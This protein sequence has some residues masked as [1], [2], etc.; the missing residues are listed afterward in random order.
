MFIQVTAS[1]GSGKTFQL[2]KRFLE[3]LLGAS[4]AQWPPVCLKAGARRHA[5]AEIMAITFTNKAAAEMKERLVA[6][7][8]AL[9]LGIECPGAPRGFTPEIARTHLEMLFKH[10]QRLQIRT[11]DSLLV[12]LARLFAVELGLAPDFETVF[13][14]AEILTPLYDRL[15]SRAEAGAEPEASLLARATAAFSGAG[16]FLPSTVWNERLAAM[17]DLRLT[18]PGELATDPR[19][20]VRLRG[21]G[22]DAL[23]S[24]AGC[25]GRELDAAGCKAKTQFAALLEKCLALGPEDKLPDSVYAAKDDFADCVLAAGRAK[26]TPGLDAGYEAFK[27]CFAEYAQTAALTG[28]ALDMLAFVELADALAHGL[29][30]GL[31]ERGRL[32]HVRVAALV[33]NALARDQGVP[34]AFCR[35]GARLAHLLIDEF[36][37]TSRA[38]WRALT[39][40]ALECLAKGGGLFLVGDVKQAIYG[41]R[42]GDARLFAE[43]ARDPELTAMAE[44][45]ILGLTDNWR[46]APRIVDFNNDFFGALARPGRARAA[47][48]A[49][50]AA[51][52]EA[53][54][55]ALAERI[56]EVFGQAAQTVPASRAG[57]PA[58]LVSIRPTPGA[59][60]QDI[61]AGVRQ[62]LREALCDDVLS[63]RPCGDAAILVGTNDLAGEVSRW[64]LDWDVPAVT[65]NS[66]RLAERPVIRQ[67]TAFL[68]FLDYPL[69]DAAFWEFASGAELFGAVSGLG[70][71]DL[72][73]WLAGQGRGALYPQFRRDFPDAWERL[74]RPYFS[75][76]GLTGAYDLAAE[77]I[78]AYRVLARLPGDEGFVRRFLEAVHV[79]GE[80]GHASLAAFLDHWRRKGAGEMAPRPQSLDAVRI[81]TVHKAKGLQFPVVIVP[82][83]AQAAPKA[84]EV[85]VIEKYGLRFA[86]KLSAHAGEPYH[87]RIEAR[88]LEQLNQLYVAWTRAAEELHLF[89][90]PEAR[91]GSPLLDTALRLLHGLGID[92]GERRVDLGERPAPVRPPAPEPPAAAAGPAPEEAPPPGVSFSPPMHWLPRLKVY[93]NAVTELRPDT[94]LTETA[95]GEAA[96]KA[97]ECLRPSAGPDADH[98]ADIDRAVRLALQSL[99]LPPEDLAGLAARLGEMLRWTLSLPEFAAHLARGEREREILDTAGNTH[100]PDLYVELDDGV[101]VVDYK[102]GAPRDEHA[103]QVRRYLRLLR[104][105]GGEQERAARGLILYLDRREARAVGLADP[106]AL[107]AGRG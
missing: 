49:L 20:F 50:A 58:G 48:D 103:D 6:S 88:S 16:G 71:A 5:P 101:L 72:F 55:Q 93:R 92:A 21:H 30:G 45:Q 105:L 29:E 102:T 77:I 22:L 34:E 43:A 60:K 107:G 27:R 76:A 98:E 90:Q 100:R 28:G 52:P 11:I 7:L 19:R 89:V 74:I 13:D 65:E 73:D 53:R 1:A 85:A 81:M 9:A 32:A 86:A 70:R 4:S 23:R 47:A 69:D 61:A 12:M 33:Q 94:V 80:K 106:D 44:P 66:L 64:L 97:L 63:R 67:L 18:E 62:A 31:G 41:W 26:L 84:A 56:G 8:K 42:G 104:E 17:F 75:Q 10:Y 82:F 79:C 99:A 38:Q 54:R 40:L 2:T 39:P 91:A 51:L 15:V 35:L 46:S 24:A 95:R 37:D 25:L 14:P 87:R 59:A 83:A 36:Q 57:G 78:K 3:L 96:H 68:S